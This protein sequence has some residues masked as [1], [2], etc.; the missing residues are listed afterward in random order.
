MLITFDPTS[1]DSSDRKERLCSDHWKRLSAI[2]ACLNELSTRYIL[3]MLGVWKLHRIGQP[4][5]RFPN[6]DKMMAGLLFPAGLWLAMSQ[7]SFSTIVRCPCSRFLHESL[8]K[9]WVIIT[10]SRTRALI[11]SR[12]FLCSMSAVIFLRTTRIQPW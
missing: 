8:L 2:L 4:T 12:A 7:M 9:W 5:R 6:I 10:C 1:P 3:K 11:M